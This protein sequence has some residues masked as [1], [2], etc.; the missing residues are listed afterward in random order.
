[1]RTVGGHTKS[2]REA[3]AGLPKWSAS[4]GIFRELSWPH[5]LPPVLL[6]PRCQSAVLTGPVRKEPSRFLC[7]WEGAREERVK[8]F[9]LVPVEVTLPDLRARYKGVR[10]AA[11]EM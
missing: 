4:I 9:R 1:M 5:I 11:G 8:D 10:G 2:G 7:Q 6:P 3:Q